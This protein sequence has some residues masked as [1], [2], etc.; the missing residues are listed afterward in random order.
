MAGTIGGGKKRGQGRPAAPEASVGRDALVEAARRLLA[1]LPPAKVTIAQIA[2]EA[3]VDPTLIRYYFGTRKALLLAVA[4]RM[5]GA[6]P[7]GRGPEQPPVDELADLI[8][9][10]FGVT[11]SA[12]QMHRLMIDELADTGSPQSR[13]WLR[14]INLGAA[15]HH[16]E[17]LARDGGVELA[18]VDPLFL[19]LTLVGIADFFAAAQSVIRELVPEGT[20]MAELGR[21]YEAFVVKLLLD[22]LRRR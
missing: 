20:D 1:Q 15:E 22:G 19:H 5:I 12:K 8:R 13:A 18:V 11:R 21:R 17:L 2:R 14:E 4:Q 16:R 3:G 6:V 7:A 10:V 9:G